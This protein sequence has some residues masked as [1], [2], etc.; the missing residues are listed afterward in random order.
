MRIF[1]I[2]VVFVAVSLGCESSQTKPLKTDDTNNPHQASSLEQPLSAEFRGRDG[3]WIVS[4]GGDLLY[5]QDGGGKWSKINAGTVERFD[6]LSF[7]DEN[8]GWVISKS[9]KL[10]RTENGGQ[11]WRRL[12]DD[13]NANG[14]H[15]AS[16]VKIQFADKLNG[17]VLGPFSIWRTVD[18]GKTWRTYAPPTQEHYHFYSLFLLDSYEGWLGGDYGIVY[19]IKDGGETWEE[20]EVGPEETEFTGIFFI[21]KSVGWV[22]GLRGELYKTMN[23][24]KS[25]RPLSF[26]IPG[27][28]WDINSIYFLNANEGWAVGWGSDASVQENKGGIVLQT[29]DGGAS[30]KEVNIK[31]TESFYELIFFADSQN[32]WVLSRRNAY[33]TVDGGKTWYKVLQLS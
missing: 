28:G 30:W 25:W 27:E 7:I 32:G 15:F 13:N 17:W 22:K 14:P 8:N 4:S 16:A 2:L 18:G 33:R 26:S 12:G 20:I 6:L 29:T 9:G 23:G 5:T 19:H 10:W 31:H 24:G 21:S 11:N 1:Q 3:A